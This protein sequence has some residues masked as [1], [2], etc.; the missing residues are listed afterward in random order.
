MG[1]QKKIIMNF[2]TAPSLDDIETLAQDA[3]EDFPTELSQYMEDAQILI[4]DFPPEELEEDMGLDSAF[5]LLAFFKKH[6]EKIAGVQAKNA[7]KEKVLYL[8]RRPI[9]DMWCETGDDL[10]AIVRHVM[11]SEIAQSHDYSE[12]EIETLAG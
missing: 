3:L 6:A 7:P 1:E 2:T 8:Y 12:D 9:L 10:A 11:I 5:E 4:E